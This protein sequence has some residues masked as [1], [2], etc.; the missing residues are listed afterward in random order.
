MLIYSG[1]GYNNQKSNQ[2]HSE[3]FRLFTHQYHKERK[4]WAMKTV[5]SVPSEIL[6]KLRWKT[7]SA[8]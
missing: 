8:H 2:R 6:E 1:I 3:L 4:L 5:R 7:E